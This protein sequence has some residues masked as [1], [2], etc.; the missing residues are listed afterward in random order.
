MNLP[1]HEVLEIL[2]TLAMLGILGI[3]RIQTVLECCA[4]LILGNL[5][6]H[7]SGTIHVF[8]AILMVPTSRAIPS[9]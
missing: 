3:L 6:V 4:I 9:S 2:P 7:S 8:P 5:A 1:F